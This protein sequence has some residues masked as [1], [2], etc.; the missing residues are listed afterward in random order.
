MV[1]KLYGH[2]LSSYSRRVAVILNEKN[3]PFEY[4]EVDLPKGEQKQEPFI[5]IQPFGTV[6]AIVRFIP[7]DS[8]IPSTS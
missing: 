8:L 1:L 6:P 7:T 3:V 5:N 2:P 4:I